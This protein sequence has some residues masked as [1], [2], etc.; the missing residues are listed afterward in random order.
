M[1]LVLALASA[2]VPKLIFDTDM[3]G[4]HCVDVVSVLCAHVPAIRLSC[5]RSLAHDSFPVAH[6]MT[7]ARSL[8]S[9]PSWSGAS[10]SC[11]RS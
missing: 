11:S 2:Q 5:L 3:G 7:W 6:R 8:C 1:M 9:V 10:S 4:G